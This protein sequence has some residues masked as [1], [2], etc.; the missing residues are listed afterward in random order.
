LADH[1]FSA[2]VVKDVGSVRAALCVA[3]TLHGGIRTCVPDDSTNAESVVMRADHASCRQGARPQPL[4]Q[5]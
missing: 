3:P 5:F 1:P 4:L 2:L